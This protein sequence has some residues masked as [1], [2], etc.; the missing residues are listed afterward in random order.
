M[1]VSNDEQAH[2]H[3]G[4]GVQ[5]VQGRLVQKGIR[6][7]L[8]IQ[9]EGVGEVLQILLTCSFDEHSIFTINSPIVGELSSSGDLVEA[10]QEAFGSKKF[11]A[12]ITEQQVD[13]IQLSIGSNRWIL[14]KDESVEWLADSQ[15]TI[16]VTN[17][18]FEMKNAVH[19]P[20]TGDVV[21]GVLVGKEWVFDRGL[22]NS[23]N[24]SKSVTGVIF[25]R[26]NQ[27]WSLLQDLCSLLVDGREQLT[28]HG[29][30]L[31]FQLVGIDSQTELF[32]RM[33][34]AISSDLNRILSF[35]I[36][37]HLSVD[38]RCAM[39]ANDVSYD[40]DGCDVEVYNR[41]VNR[42]KYKYNISRI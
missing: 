16:R 38:A 17:C 8:M 31:A 9:S 32:E 41:E 5:V 13:D 4:H 21:V 3:I 7:K 1:I 24:K 23:L 20:R 10:L 18:C 19:S 11:A 35:D 42:T 15:K 33:R 27:S 14:E 37:S 22:I 34:L 25:Q 40:L 26:Q 2:S 30:E 39:I 28:V 6:S 12:L 29:F 36:E